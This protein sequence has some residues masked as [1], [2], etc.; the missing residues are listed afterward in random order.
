[1]EL[2]IM[3]KMSREIVRRICL[4][5]VL[6]L[7]VFALACGGGS[8]FDPSGDGLLDVDFTGLSDITDVGVSASV[9]GLPEREVRLM[10]IDYLQNLVVHSEEMR[11]VARDLLDLAGNEEMQLNLEWVRLVHEV[12]YEADDLQMEGYRLVVAS[13]LDSDYD[14]LHA[15]YLNGMQSLGFGSDHVL[16]GALI[17]GPDDR[18]VV[19]LAT[20]QRQQLRA[21]LGKG[22]FFLED[23]DVLFTSVLE[24][25]EEM[26]DQLRVSESALRFD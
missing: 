2:V 21:N 10:R 15:G 18:A 24:N 6:V 3:P 25:A 7:L 17:L 22:V 26:I 23:A 13:G 19:E 11:Q 9:P 1:M 12:T 5:M 20:A 14:E 4:T 8:D 16:D